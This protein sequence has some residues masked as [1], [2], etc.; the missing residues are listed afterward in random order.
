MSRVLSLAA[1]LFLLCA[2]PAAAITYGQSDGNL[3]PEV[4]AL[5][6]QFSS[7]T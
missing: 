1:L 5:V 3:H 6:G 4:G 2:L 7:G